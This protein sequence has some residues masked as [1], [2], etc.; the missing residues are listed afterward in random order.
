MLITKT[1]RLQPLSEEGM[2]LRVASSLQH[3]PVGGSDAWFLFIVTHGHRSRS[4]R[5]LLPWPHV[6]CSH[7]TQDKTAPLGK[8]TLFSAQSSF[9]EGKVPLL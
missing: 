3:K 7:A 1:N 4:V 5:V 2:S 8:S 6:P 9:F